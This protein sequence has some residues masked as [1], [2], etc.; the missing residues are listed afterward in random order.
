M[1]TNR[2]SLLPTRTIART[3]VVAAVALI[4]AVAWHITAQANV[5]RIYTLPFYS[6]SAK[7]CV[8]GSACYAGHAGTD[9]QFGDASTGGAAVLAAYGGSVHQFPSQGSAGNYVVIDHGNTHMTRYLH[10]QGFVA[11]NNSNVPQGGI[12]AYEGNTGG[13]W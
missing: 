4:T 1:R 8:F 7:T 3:G 10:L 2:W 5:D 6:S 11:P 9:Y 12:L 13:P